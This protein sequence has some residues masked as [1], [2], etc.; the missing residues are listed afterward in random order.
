MSA[1]SKIV[2]IAIAG[3]LIVFGLVMLVVRPVLGSVL[4]ANQEMKQTQMELATIDQQILA[5]QSAKNDIEKAS[6]RTE[7][8]GR[9]VN[10]DNLV[11][12]VMELEQAAGKT[13]T[14]EILDI[15]D[16]DPKNPMPDPIPGK[17]GIAEVHYRITTSNDYIGLF[18][19]LGYLEHLPHG[20]EID[21]IFPPRFR[22]PS[23]PWS[24]WI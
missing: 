18:N 24:G 17:Q 22:T 20:T 21:K 2:S 13:G 12:P 11:V 15:K 8:A 1:L 10:Q 19:F 16:P 5:F 9:I 6:R 23:A 3:I 4:A 7:I 14:V